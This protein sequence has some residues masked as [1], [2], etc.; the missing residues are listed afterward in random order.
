MKIIPLFE[1]ALFQLPQRLRAEKP[2]Y[3]MKD[4]TGVFPLAIHM[5]NKLGQDY[6]LYVCNLTDVI[7]EEYSLA[8]KDSCFRTFPSVLF[9]KL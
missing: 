5:S 2:G 8:F 3:N 1:P 6:W 4:L 9:Q 7:R